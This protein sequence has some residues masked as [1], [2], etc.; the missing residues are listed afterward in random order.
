[1][2]VRRGSELSR[3]EVVQMLRLDPRPVGPSGEPLATRPGTLSWRRCT[4]IED[5]GLR[6]SRRIPFDITM[7]R[8]TSRERP[9]VGRRLG[10]LEGERHVLVAA[11]VIGRSFSFQLVRLLLDRSTSTG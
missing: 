10:R 2:G 6:R 9:P 7:T 3:D 5:G 4:F 11:A 1:M 8:S